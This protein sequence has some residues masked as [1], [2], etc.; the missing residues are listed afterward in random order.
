M[1]APKPGVSFAKRWRICVPSKSDIEE[2]ERVLKDRQT[3][4]PGSHHGVHEN[5]DHKDADLI[6]DVGL[7]LIE[8]GR[9]LRKQRDAMKSKLSVP[10]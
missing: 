7:W 2:F 1:S 9:H 3:M 6:V 5:W 4:G 10:T 8:R